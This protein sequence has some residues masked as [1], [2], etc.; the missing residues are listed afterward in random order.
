MGADGLYLISAKQRLGNPMRHNKDPVTVDATKMK[1][2]M[3]S[4]HTAIDLGGA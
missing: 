2:H 4:K 3:G 1:N